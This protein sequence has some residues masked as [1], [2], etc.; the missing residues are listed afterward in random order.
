MII[1][2][3]NPLIRDNL[4]GSV[5]NLAP[6]AINKS[7]SKISGNGSI[8]AVK[9]FTLFISNEEYECYH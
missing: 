6:N 3:A 8:R 9:G 1:D 4:L 7:V 5:S 2:L